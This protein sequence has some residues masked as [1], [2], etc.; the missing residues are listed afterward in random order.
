MDDPNV[1][2]EDENPVVVAACAAL[3]VSGN[4]WERIGKNKYRNKVSLMNLTVE[5]N[6]VSL[7]Q[8]DPDRPRVAYIERA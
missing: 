6:K 3:H 4:G 5:G 7:T 8:R 2:S 1:G